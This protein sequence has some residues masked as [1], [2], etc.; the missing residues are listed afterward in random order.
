[1]EKGKA[2]MPKSKSNVSMNEDLE[3]DES[4]YQSASDVNIYQRL[5]S[6]G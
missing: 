2:V 1:M 4:D 3:D 6:H 5:D